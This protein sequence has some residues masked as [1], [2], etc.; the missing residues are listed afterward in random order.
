VVR[1]EIGIALPT[2]I[3]PK[4]DPVLA[5]GELQGQSSIGRLGLVILATLIVRLGLG[6]RG[7]SKPTVRCRQVRVPGTSVTLTTRRPRAHKRT[8]GCRG[9]RNRSVLLRVQ[10]YR[11]GR[12]C[13]VWAGHAGNRGF[14]RVA[15]V[16]SSVDNFACSD[17]SICLACR[18]IR[19][20]GTYLYQ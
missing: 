6:R 17:M 3:A 13:V 9:C 14:R 11:R 18:E 15:I 19:D 5:V 8:A 10:S 16:G 20:P 2:N 7:I 4:V 1:F 12:R